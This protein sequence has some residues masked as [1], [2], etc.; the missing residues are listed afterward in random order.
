LR[1]INLDNHHH[2][3]QK[4]QHHQQ[5]DALFLI[6]NEVAIMKKVSKPR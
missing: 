1:A 5:D 4:Y 2:Q 6:R 3:H